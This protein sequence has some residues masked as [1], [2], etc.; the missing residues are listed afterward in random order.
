MPKKISEIANMLQTSTQLVYR[1]IKDLGPDFAHK[2]ID[3]TN[4][5]KEV[6]D[7]GMQILLD[8]FSHQP[9][10]DEIERLR[11]AL[12]EARDELRQEREHS[13]RQ[14]E[15][16]AQLAGQMVD[17]TRNSQVLLKQYQD[18]QQIETVADTGKKRHW[19]NFGQGGR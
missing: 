7:D 6:R 2:F 4:G 8:T 10:V 17:L 13:R 19:W 3:E 15:Q 1:H 9:A 18:Q 14:S 12:A 11:T 16:L 5:K